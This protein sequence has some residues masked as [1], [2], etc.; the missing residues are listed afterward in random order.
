M[1]IRVYEIDIEFST[2]NSHLAKQ[3]HQSII[4]LLEKHEDLFPNKSFPI[5]ESYIDNDDYD[6]DDDDDYDFDD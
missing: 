4:K 2:S 1:S 6:D 3:I 5:L